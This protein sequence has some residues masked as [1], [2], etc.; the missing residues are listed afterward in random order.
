MC[1]CVCLFGGRVRGSSFSLFSLADVYTFFAFYKDLNY[2]SAVCG[3]I[4]TLL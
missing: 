2:M 1:V 4:Q 3:T